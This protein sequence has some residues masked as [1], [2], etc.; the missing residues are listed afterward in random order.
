MISDN[1]KFVLTPRSYWRLLDFVS[2]RGEKVSPR[3]LNTFE[4]INATLTLRNPIDRVIPDRERKMNIGFAIAEWY[5][6]MFGVDDINFF[7]KF[8]KSYSK[9]SSDGQKL[10]GCYGTRIN[11]CQST[12]GLI[13]SVNQIDEVVNKLKKD[14]D[15]RQAVVAIYSKEDLIGAG[16][17]NTPCTMTLQFLLRG[18]NLHTIV[19][20]RSS[21][22]VKGL[23]YDVFVFTMVQEYVARQLQVPLGHYYHNAGSLHLYETD[24]DLLSKLRRKYRW[25][26]LMLEMPTTTPLDV[27]Q[28]RTLV[29]QGL[30]DD[31]TFFEIAN[32]K[33]AWSSQ[34]VQDYFVGLAA[35]MKSFV[36]RHSNPEISLKALG[37]VGDP[38]LKFVLRGWLID[39]GVIRSNRQT[40]AISGKLTG[41]V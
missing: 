1:H 30:D 26:H 9:F 2:K 11:F 20:M 3:G 23:T 5:S 15:S 37:L 31:S 18:G 7:T 10:D 8:I 27:V 24:L 28:F 34:A 4:L 21:D 35:V 14:P 36:H 33:K 32:D 29:D 16:G 39:A 12:A 22:V 19:N 6:F 17:L 40:H 38:T 13:S 25:P 41:S